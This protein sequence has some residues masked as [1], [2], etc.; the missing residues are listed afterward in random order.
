M[1]VSKLPLS[2]LPS[3]HGFWKPDKG[4]GISGRCERLEIQW[5][6]LA[7][8][9]EVVSDQLL[10]SPIGHNF[11]GHNQAPKLSG[12]TQMCSQDQTGLCHGQG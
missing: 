12:T 11:Q 8:Y 2:V 6:C 5:H 9:F 4:Y 7:D 10:W 1:I 3:N